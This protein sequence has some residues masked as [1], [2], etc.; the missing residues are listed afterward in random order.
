MDKWDLIVDFVGKLPYFALIALGL[1]GSTALAT[2]ETKSYGE[3]YTTKLDVEI[4]DVFI[5][6]EVEGLIWVYTREYCVITYLDQKGESTTIKLIYPNQNLRLVY[7][8]R[9]D[10]RYVVTDVFHNR[11]TTCIFGPLTRFFDWD[12]ETRRCVSL[13]LGTKIET[14]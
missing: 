14:K 8:N 1:F 2:A 5:S 3:T 13:P 10:K 12:F 9:T 11:T 4:Y 7:E 6:K